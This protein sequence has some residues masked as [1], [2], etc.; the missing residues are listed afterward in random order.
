MKKTCI[1]CKRPFHWRK[2]GQ[3]AGKM[4]VIAQNDVGVNAEGLIMDNPPICVWFKRDLRIDD[5]VPLY[6]A[7]QLGTV[8]LFI[9]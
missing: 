8:L 1:V 9:S 5:H 6:E 2:N 3:P 7:A 4:C